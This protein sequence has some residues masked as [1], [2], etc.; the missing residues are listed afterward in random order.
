MTTKHKFAREQIVELRASDMTV[1]VQ[2]IALPDG[3]C[4]G[5]SLPIYGCCRGGDHF[6]CCE[7]NLFE[8]PPEIKRK[9]N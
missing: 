7:A 6:T 2:I 1:P 4:H 3:R 5:H 8:L 9:L